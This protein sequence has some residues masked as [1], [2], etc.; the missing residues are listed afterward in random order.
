[1]INP[2]MSSSLEELWNFRWHQLF[3]TSWV[4]FGFRPARYIAQRALTKKVKNTL[5]ISLLAGTLAVFFLSGLTHEYMIYVTVGW[6]VYRRLFIGQQLFFFFAHGAGVTL[7]RFVKKLSKS[8]LPPFV[9][10][11]FFVRHIASRLWVFSFAFLTFPFFMDGFS[12]NQIWLD[13]PL[14]FSRPYVFEFFRSVAPGLGKAIC[15]NL[16]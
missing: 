16:L 4:A 7:E 10:E 11:S 6:S 8:Y 14:T 5:P 13:N 15:G 3:H 1:M 9:R 12:Y 2:V